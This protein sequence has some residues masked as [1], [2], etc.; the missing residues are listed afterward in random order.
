MFTLYHIISLPITV[1]SRFRFVSW[2]FPLPSLFHWPRV[3]LYLKVPNHIYMWKRSIIHWLIYFGFI[4]CLNSRVTENWVTNSSYAWPSFVKKIHAMS[5]IFNF[6]REILISHIW[7]I[8]PIS[9]VKST[10]KFLH[11]LK[12]FPN[13]SFVCFHWEITWHLGKV[14]M[15]IKRERERERERE[16]TIELT[17]SPRVWGSRVSTSPLVYSLKQSINYCCR[18]CTI[19]CMIFEKRLFIEALWRPLVTKY[20]LCKLLF[21]FQNNAWWII[22]AF[23]WTKY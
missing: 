20:A 17:L 9:Q 2:S 5:F 7:Q 13:F 16:P 23:R 22:S 6:S 8:F 19:L 21:P 18:I 3:H 15:N 10:R 11:A 14:K 12:V 1:L 4:E